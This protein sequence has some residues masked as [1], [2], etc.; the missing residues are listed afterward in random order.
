M[1]KSINEIGHKWKVKQY[2]PL[3]WQQYIIIDR[4]NVNF[5]WADTRTIYTNKDGSHYIR[6]MHKTYYLD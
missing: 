6:F 5:N 2:G 3:P 4:W 1:R